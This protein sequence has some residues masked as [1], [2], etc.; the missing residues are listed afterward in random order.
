MIMEYKKGSFRNIAGIGLVD[1]EIKFEY[2]ID[3]EQPHVLFTIEAG[4]RC[5]WDRF[6]FCVKYLFGLV[7]LGCM[8]RFDKSHHASCQAI[9]TY[10]K[11]AKKKA[12]K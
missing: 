5:F 12:S 4:H 9:A 7:P 11:G 1:D 8:F 2:P 10:L 6:I 3:V